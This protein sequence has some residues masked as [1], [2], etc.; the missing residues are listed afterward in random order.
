L[1]LSPDSSD[2]Q[3]INYPSKK[4]FTEIMMEVMEDAFYRSQHGK[5]KE[6]E[7]D[8]KELIEKARKQI[9]AEKQ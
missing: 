1:T 9:K 7:V 8:E 3:V 5:E 6:E 2:L 4:E